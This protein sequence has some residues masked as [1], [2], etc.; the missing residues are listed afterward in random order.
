[1]NPARSLAQQ[2]RTRNA[3]QDI[4][5]SRVKT[6]ND[7]GRSK[8]RKSPWVDKLTLLVTK[9]QAGEAEVGK[10][11][12]LGEFVAPSGARNAIR[13]IGAKAGRLP[14]VTLNLQSTTVDLEGGKKGS[15]LWAAVEK[16]EGQ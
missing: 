14:N 5:L 11:Y 6:T 1:M 16:G 10:F 7:F 2:S 4:D 13:N 3:T 15:Q 12:L 8:V 9:V